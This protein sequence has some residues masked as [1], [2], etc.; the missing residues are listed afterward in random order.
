MEKKIV[1]TGMI[2]IVIEKGTV[3][4]TGMTEET[5]ANETGRNFVAV[6]TERGWFLHQPKQFLYNV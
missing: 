4:E 1:V 5:A 2:E 6:M 3:I